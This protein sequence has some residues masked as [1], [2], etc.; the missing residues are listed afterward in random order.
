MAQSIQR[1]LCIGQV[2][3]IY[4]QVLE[5]ER[6]LNIYL[7]LDYIPGKQYPILYLLDGS[8]HE[9]F[10]QI[11]GLVQFYNRHYEMPECIVVGIVNVDRQHDF[12]FHS[13]NK[14]LQ[15]EY[16]SAG[17]SATFINFIEK[18][19]MPF[20]MRN[21]GTNGQEMI[22]GQS[23]GGLL[24]CEILLTKPQLFTDYLIISPSLWWDNES[25]LENAPLLLAE[26]ADT[27]KPNSV[28]IA[29]GGDEDPTTKK[30]AKKFSSALKKDNRPNQ[31]IT[32]LVL[33]DE[34]KA[35]I[36]HQGVSE[37]FK[38]MYPLKE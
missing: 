14:E 4:S 5:Q 37:I 34:N 2:H 9:D 3:R 29:V 10:M 26:Q 30:E 31:N 36:L 32:Y 15:I 25:L 22:I 18:E 19:L 17:S 38:L 16:P 6:S 27:L 11:A 35:S 21:F 23:L 8:I 13:D 28:Y 20:I 12:T 1:P 33:K 7:P 24:A